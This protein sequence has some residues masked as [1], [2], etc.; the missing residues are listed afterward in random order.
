M[1]W[2]CSSSEV[3]FRERGK[4]SDNETDCN[5]GFRRESEDK[6]TKYTSY[7]LIRNA[8][9]SH[10]R[11]EMSKVHSSRT[12]ILDLELVIA[13]PI[14]AEVEGHILRSVKCGPDRRFDSLPASTLLLISRPAPFHP[15]PSLGHSLTS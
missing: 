5:V 9:A 2:V 6:S 3:C 7:F 13:D 8:N 11:S 4:K 12:E 1:Y 14:V 15:G 10:L